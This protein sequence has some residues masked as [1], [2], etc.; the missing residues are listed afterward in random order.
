MATNDVTT[1]PAYGDTGVR[2][3]GGTTGR[4]AQRLTTETKSFF[5]TSE[6]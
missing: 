2:D 6:F 1:G 5:K 4:F 3:R